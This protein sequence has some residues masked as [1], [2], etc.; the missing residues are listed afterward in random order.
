MKE[1][2]DGH[3]DPSNNRLDRR[4]TGPNQQITRL[5]DVYRNNSSKSW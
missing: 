5:V 4:R 3:A 1:K 2:H